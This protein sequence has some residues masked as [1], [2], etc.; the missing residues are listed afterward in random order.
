M[1]SRVGVT[2]LRAL[3]LVWVAITG[4]CALGENGKFTFKFNETATLHGVVKNVY[5]HT[6][7]AFKLRCESNVS[8]E[9]IK[10]GWIIRETQVRRPT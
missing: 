4:V 8:Q 5:N 1:T 2:C 7:V 9:Q 3:L 6:R 10:I